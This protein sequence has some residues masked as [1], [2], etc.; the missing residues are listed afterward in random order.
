MTNK[1]NTNPDQEPKVSGEE[2]EEYLEEKKPE[3]KPE[4]KPKP[5]EPAAPETAAPSPP[6]AP[7]PSE[8]APVPPP[9]PEPAA[10]Q[11]PAPPAP[12]PQTPTPSPAVQPGAELGPRPIPASEELEPPS[13]ETKP[14]P[15][16][17][18]PEPPKSVLPPGEPLAEKPGTGAS[19]EPT[20]PPKK[21]SKFKSFCAIF[22]IIFLLIIAGAAA[23]W[24]FL[25]TGNLVLSVTPADVKITVD[26]QTASA[27]ETLKLK[28]AQYLVKIEK[29]DYVSYEKEITIT[30]LK[31]ETIQLELKLIPSPEQIFS[32][33]IQDFYLI[34]GDIIVL[35]NSGK[36]LY[37]LEQQAL[38]SEVKGRQ[39][40]E[41]E[42]AT[43]E[44]T[45]PSL[46][47]TAITPD[48]LANVQDIIWH[49]LESLAIFKIKQDKSKLANTPFANSN[50]ANG[51]EMTWLYDFKRYDLVSQESHFW[52]ADIGD[53]VWSPDGESVYYYYA[54]AG[55]EKTLISA[56]KGNQNLER[57]LNLKEQEIESPQISI[58]PDGKYLSFVPRSKNYET[59]Y[60]YLLEILTKK[61]TKIV[62]TGNNLGAKFSSDS[63]KALFSAYSKN[64]EEPAE[65]SALSVVD[66]EG[67]N[68]KELDRRAFLDRASFGS[69][70]EYVIVATSDGKDKSDIFYKID[71][72][73][74]EKIEYVFTSKDIIKPEKIL[75]SSDNGYTYFVISDYL[76]KL[77]LVSSKYQ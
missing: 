25:A 58:S 46:T 14:E 36:T 5:A 50:V 32:E 75:F 16:E 26:G 2:L 34:N 73:S 60:V 61:L 15:S 11:S 18:A 37:K 56:S 4:P 20:E 45:T 68:K 31:T 28:P 49:P 39:T 44:E 55:G 23:W 63:Q 48:T 47:K 30:K 69:S 51:K 74:G 43:K 59:N 77:E 64:E 53:I 54:P 52:G 67:K 35:G 22:V 6:S 72:E 38:Q 41:G 65:Y 9:E 1:D 62:E 7:E 57:L 70:S 13:A 33:K 24:Y 3:E 76:Y 29:Q 42:D 17:V 21:P 27:S 19:T 12:A 66:V 40:E 71:I 10:P 8:A